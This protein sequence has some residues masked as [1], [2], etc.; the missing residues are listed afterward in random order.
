MV[1]DGVITGTYDRQIAKKGRFSGAAKYTY[2]PIVKYEL[3][4]LESIRRCNVNSS[5]KESFKEGEILKLYWSPS[6]NGIRERCANKILLVAG[7]L[8]TVAGIL[9]GASIVVALA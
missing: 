2:Y 3:E 5:R 1:V 8:L 9:A 6:E 7:I 4:G